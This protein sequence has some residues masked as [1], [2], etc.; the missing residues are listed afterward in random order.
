M[1][2]SV[3]TCNIRHAAREDFRGHEVGTRGYW[4]FLMI[5]PSVPTPRQLLHK[6]SDRIIIRV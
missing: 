1:R 3:S 6:N 4:L 2:I 5:Y